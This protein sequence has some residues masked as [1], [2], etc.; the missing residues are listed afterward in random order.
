[1][2]LSNSDTVLQLQEPQEDQKFWAT[3]QKIL[4]DNFTNDA[5]PEYFALSPRRLSKFSLLEPKDKFPVDFISRETSS[6]QQIFLWKYGPHSRGA[7]APL[8]RM[9]LWETYGPDEIGE[10]LW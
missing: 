2:V 10:V 6:G 8:D 1:M 5:P 3:I 9:M 7:L 4:Y